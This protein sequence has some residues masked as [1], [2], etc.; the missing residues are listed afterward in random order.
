MAA[1]QTSILQF[2]C[3]IIY[4]GSVHS[5]MLCKFLQNTRFI[6][7]ASVVCFINCWWQIEV[8]PLQGIWELDFMDFE[9]DW[10]TT[11]EFGLVQL[12]KE[13]T[14]ITVPL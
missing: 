11:L 10:D 12:Q 7:K 1:V 6:S 2:T 4:L 13:I 9:F 3:K 14:M 5:V 8:L